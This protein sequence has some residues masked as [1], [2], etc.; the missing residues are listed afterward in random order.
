MNIYEITQELR[1][2]YDEIEANEGE[3]TDDIATKLEL[4]TE[5][6]NDKAESY[7]ALIRN[8]TADAEAYKAEIDRLTKRKRTAE[9]LVSRL[10]EALR[11]AMIMGDQQKIKAGLFN[12]S[13]RT[14]AA[15]DIEDETLIP[16]D[17]FQFERKIMK[18]A[19]KD[20]IKE[21]KAVSGAKI[22]ENVSLSI[23]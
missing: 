16:D 21:G 10:K 14:T 15:V 5:Q 18:S 17:Y 19:I 4:T 6:L 13:L 9:N 2:I 11:V 23:R 7:C 22:V 1:A 20:A 12:L 8:V 3:V